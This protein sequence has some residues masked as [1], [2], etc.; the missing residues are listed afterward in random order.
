MQRKIAMSLAAVACLCQPFYAQAKSW[1]EVEVFVFER[2]GQTNTEQWQNT[3]PQ[4]ISANHIDLISPIITTDITG[5]ALGLSGCI[6]TDWLSNSDEQTNCDP[7]AKQQAQ[8]HP[9]QVPMSIAAETEQQAYLGD[10]PV[11][12]AQSQSQFTDI[13]DSISKERN[14]KPL[15]HLTWQ[16]DM[17]PRRQAT[18]VR[19]YAGKDYSEQFHFQG[20]PV[21]QTDTQSQEPETPLYLNDF[22][23]FD[24]MIGTETVSP[25]WQLDGMINIY[26][27]HYLFI[28]HDL[29]LRKVTQKE[30]TATDKGTVS[31]IAGYNRYQT[32]TS[33]TTTAQLA[34]ISEPFLQAIP[35]KQNRR[36]RSGQVH[37]FDHPNMGI[38]M[39]IR[40][41]EQPETARPIDLTP[42]EADINALPKSQV[43]LQ[44]NTAATN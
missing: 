34:L 33:S 16:Q 26:L 39:Q 19:I 9:S 40:R 44:D 32:D 6:S 4:A 8:T 15:L 38:V 30:V 11:L 1:F 13:I 29:F 37:Y 7:L 22:S 36:V 20:S 24:F 3:P 31:A 5:V 18:P 42:N 28:E 21:S 27:N 12:L 14:V 23:N 17:Q 43:E 35:L 25:V 41:M 2:E 10:A